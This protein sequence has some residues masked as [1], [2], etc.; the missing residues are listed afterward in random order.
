MILGLYISPFAKLVPSVGIEYT[1]SLLT[2]VGILFGVWAIILGNNAK[3][4]N[5]MNKFIYVNI[6]LPAFYFSLGLLI[7]SVTF[8][9]L[10]GF[11][12]YSPAFLLLF[13]ALS[14][15]VNVFLLVLLAKGVS[16]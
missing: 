12:L 16:S 8:L 6:V 13:N 15:G 4:Q 1:N 11:G 2:V 9:T 3:N 5:S 7:L 10:T 14:I